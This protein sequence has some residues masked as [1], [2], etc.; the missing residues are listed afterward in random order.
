MVPA[1]WTVFWLPASGE[2]DWWYPPLY[3]ESDYLRGAWY[4]VN[5]GGARHLG[6][7]YG[8]LWATRHQGKRL[9]AFRKALRA[10]RPDVIEQEC[11]VV[12]WQDGDDVVTAEVRRECP[13]LGARCTHRKRGSAVQIA[14]EK[15]RVA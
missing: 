5:L 13:A 7:K 12:R 1:D 3:F 4:F 6:Y 15:E 2:R 8:R 9:D 10:M 14:P 11:R